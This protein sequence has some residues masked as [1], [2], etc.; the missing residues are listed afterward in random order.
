MRGYCAAIASQRAKYGDGSAVAAATTPVAAAAPVGSPPQVRPPHRPTS[1]KRLSP[2]AFSLTSGPESNP[3]RTRQPRRPS[4]ERSKSPSGIK[5]ARCFAFL[6]H[7]Y[8]YYLVLGSCNHA[9]F[10][11]AFVS[12][13]ALFYRYRLEKKVR[14]STR[15]QRPSARRQPASGA[16]KKNA[17]RPS[18]GSEAA[19]LTDSPP[20]P[21]VTAGE[22][23]TTPDSATP[24]EELLLRTFS[25][26]GASAVISDVKIVSG[27]NGSYALYQVSLTCGNQ[28]WCVWRR[29][30]QFAALRSLLVKASETRRAPSRPS[31]RNSSGGS[32]ANA[33]DASA[34]VGLPAFP[35]KTFWKHLDKNFLENRQERLSKFL[36]VIA[37]DEVL[38]D[39]DDVREFL[40]FGS[41]DK[42][43]PSFSSS[44]SIAG[45]STPS[46]APGSPPASRSSGYWARFSEAVGSRSGSSMATR[47]P[48][49]AADGVG[50]V[51][52][53]VS[54]DRTD[55]DDSLVDVGRDVEAMRGA[56]GERAS[57]SRPAPQPAAAVFDFDTF[58]FDDVNPDLLAVF[59]DAHRADD[60]QFAVR[61]PDYMTK[62]AKVAAGDALGRLLH[63]DIFRVEGERLRDDHILSKGRARARLE[64][65]RRTSGAPFVFSMCLQLPGSPPLSMVAYWGVAAPDPAAAATPGQIAA[66]NLFDRFIDIPISPEGGVGDNDDRSEGDLL[67]TSLQNARFKLI[68][69]IDEGPFA[70]RRAVGSKPTLLGQKVKQRYFRGVDYFEVDVE[71]GSSVIATHIVGMCRG[72][73]RLLVV[74]LGIVIQGE[75]P[76]ELPE[77][78]V[79][80]L[81]LKNIT[82]DDL[83]EDL[84]LENPDDVDDADDADDADGGYEGTHSDE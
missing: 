19:A 48:I 55:S 12:A 58:R 37:C 9:L 7:L 30:K 81:T 32:G 62:K 24:H 13:S 57:H 83:Y 73:A 75:A 10:C 51:E 18:N 45:S 72:A 74:K 1:L 69:R 8:L 65:L 25:A 41:T 2:T 26:K 80:A 47:S 44:A 54:E 22:W 17:R 40:G 61:G 46:C 11:C 53:N 60:H 16:S 59:G 28:H 79:G 33:A 3:L 68:P 21:R 43:R 36:E 78:V 15:A 34:A 29:F 35:S 56:G 42:S 6:V 82:F 66:R 49:T 14:P 70:V 4:A 67:M 71:V 23:G 84:Y 77:E 50:G 76:E 39:R 63:I 31:S 5:R 38:C 64:Q 52:R 20:P 27:T